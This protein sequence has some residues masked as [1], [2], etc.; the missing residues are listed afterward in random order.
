[1][2]LLPVDLALPPHISLTPR[3]EIPFSAYVKQ[4]ATSK[5]R[6]ALFQSYTQLPAELQLKVSISASEIEHDKQKSS[7]FTGTRVMRRSDEVQTH[8]DEFRYSEGCHKALLVARRPMIL[9]RCH[10]YRRYRKNGLQTPYPRI[11]SLSSTS[12][13]S[14]LAFGLDPPHRQTR[15]LSSLS[16]RFLS[17]HWVA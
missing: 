3:P 6:H 15:S 12:S 4:S 11:R 16:T 14:K 2:D 17:T 9:H 1:M 10:G 7:S 13:K 8:A 5:H